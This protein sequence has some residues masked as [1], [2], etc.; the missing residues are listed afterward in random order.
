M[1]SQVGWTHIVMG[2]QPVLPLAAVPDGCVDV[3]PKVVGQHSVLS[4][5]AGRG[6]LSTVYFFSLLGEG[7]RCCSVQVWVLSAVQFPEAID[8][9]RG[10][11]GVMFPQRRALPSKRGFFSCCSGTRDPFRLCHSQVGCQRVASCKFP[12]STKWIPS[13]VSP[14]GWRDAGTTAPK[15]RPDPVSS[16]SV[17]PASSFASRRGPTARVR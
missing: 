3:L 14:A 4:F 16:A 12:F 1:R 5:W 15:G 8:V 9:W 13:L 11:P 2:D 17:Y 6:C 7:Q 10:Q